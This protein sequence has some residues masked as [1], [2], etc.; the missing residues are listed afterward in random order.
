MKIIGYELHIETYHTLGSIFQALKTKGLDADLKLCDENVRL[1]LKHQNGTVYEFE[2][3][4]YKEYD[5]YKVYE[6]K[7][8]SEAEMIYIRDVLKTL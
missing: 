1:S 8:E 3:K 7:A 4:I 5:G 2:V 6:I